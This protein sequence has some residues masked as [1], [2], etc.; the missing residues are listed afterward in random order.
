MQ[1]SIRKVA[2]SSLLAMLL[3]LVPNL[4]QDTH[5][6]WGHHGYNIDNIAHRGLQLHNSFEKC[7]VC[8]FEFNIIDEPTNFIFTSIPHATP[9]V[10]VCTIDNQILNKAFHYYNL[11]APPQA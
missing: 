9:F 10:S 3:Y 4:V 6:I 8:V 2:L 5:R 1:N 11:R 7:A